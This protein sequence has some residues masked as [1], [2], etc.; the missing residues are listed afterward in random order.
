MARRRAPL[1]HET[2]AAVQR[3]AGDSNL[4]P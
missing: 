2:L 1:D 3:A 4:R